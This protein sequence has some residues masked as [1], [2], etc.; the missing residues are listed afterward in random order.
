MGYAARSVDGRN[1]LE[2]SEVVRRRRMVRNNSPQ[3]VAPEQI[4]RIV[5]AARRTPSA[6]FTQ[7]QYLVVITEAETR[8]RLA[9][10]ADERSYV[11]R[12]LD[13]WISA[14]P[15][16]IAVCT[17][18][19]EYHRRYRE[20][21][22]LDAEGR[23]MEWPVPYWWVDAG[24][25]LMTLLLSAVDEGLAA[26]FFGFHRLEGLDAILELPPEVVPI[27]VVT[28]GHPAADRRSSSLDRGRRSLGDVVR[29]ERW[30]TPYRRSRSA[31]EVVSDRSNDRAGGSA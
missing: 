16:H 27:G 14:A 10:L 18:E 23:E 20:P 8:A 9:E 12:G 11:A 17:S 21:D 3:P 6:G 7:A 19:A 31:E 5:D 25:V 22:K 28:L 13:P 4:D 29:A 24:A 30:G 15:V 1:T 26:G 2:F